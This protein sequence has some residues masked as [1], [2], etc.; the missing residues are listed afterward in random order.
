MA[1]LVYAQNDDVA[2]KKVIKA[3]TESY[4]KRD[5][6]TWSSVWVHDA[7]VN[8]KFIS[9]Y[10]LYA[11]DGWDS[12]AALRERMFRE[13]PDPIPIQLKQ[14]NYIIRSNGNFAWVEYDQDLF[15]PGLD[16]STGAGFSR[17]YRV[18]VKQNGQWKIA[19][20]ILSALS[21]ESSK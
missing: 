4:F 6:K 5:L 15:Y 14:A 21:F 17:E 20:Q 1:F 18:L 16:T 9:R 13:K 8:R 10:G 2:I 19:S 12:I 7:Q 3:E 11:N